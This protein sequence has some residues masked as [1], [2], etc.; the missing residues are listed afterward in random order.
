M[1]ES[2]SRTVSGSTGVPA[3]NVLVKAARA[4]SGGREA[5][6]SVLNLQVTLAA[7]GLPYRSVMLSARTSVY[8]QS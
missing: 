5:A 3:E 7:R 6:P 2:G 1:I 8:R 4:I